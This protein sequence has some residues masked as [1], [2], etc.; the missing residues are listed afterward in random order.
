MINFRRHNQTSILLNHFPDL[1]SKPDVFQD[2]EYYQDWLFHILFQSFLPKASL[3]KI[4][5]KFLIPRFF[6]HSIKSKLD[7][8]L[9]TKLSL[10]L[11]L[12]WTGCLVLV[13]GLFP[14]FRIFFNHC[15]NWIFPT[16]KEGW[17][18]KRV[19]FFTSCFHWRWYINITCIFWR[20]P[21]N[22]E[23][24]I[25]DTKLIAIGIPIQAS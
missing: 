6:T 7:S 9:F 22:S 16:S 23:P 17:W 3:L 2:L 21:I 8:D 12:N 13:I 24:N 1:C 25:F 11:E 4:S 14:L 10:E 15:S 20:L 19:M 18:I 5:C